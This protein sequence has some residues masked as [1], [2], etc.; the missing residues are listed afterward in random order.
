MQNNLSDKIILNRNKSTNKEILRKQRRNKWTIIM[1]ILYLVFGSIFVFIGH[2]VSSVISVP[3]FFISCFSP[4][5]AARLWFKTQTK[6]K[7][8]EIKSTLKMFLLGGPF[9]LIFLSA[10]D[11]YKGFQL[12]NYRKLTT[13]VVVDTCSQ[14]YS[15]GGTT[16]YYAIIL[17]TIEKSKRQR[18]CYMNPKECNIGDD[19]QECWAKYI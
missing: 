1:A 16:S 18:T 10:K 19:E 8:Q 17:C 5:I 6:T 12:K 13:G 11:T 9:V 7:W 2:K 14:Y 4:F 3:C 15:R